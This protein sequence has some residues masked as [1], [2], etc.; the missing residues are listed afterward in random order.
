MELWFYGL[1]YNRLVPYIEEILRGGFL[2]ERPAVFDSRQTG[3]A[4]EPSFRA[5]VRILID[6][7]NFYG[8][9]FGLCLGGVLLGIKGEA[10]WNCFMAGCY[11][12]FIVFTLP[13]RE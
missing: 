9:A 3:F 8:E 12:C 2:D 1:F 6:L 13:G 4:L 10:G 5:S 7:P 11:S